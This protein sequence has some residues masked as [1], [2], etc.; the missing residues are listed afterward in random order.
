MVAPHFVS[1]CLQQHR[2]V[3]R[4]LSHQLT[5]SAPGEYTKRLVLIGSPLVICTLLDSSKVI[6]TA[7]YSGPADLGSFHLHLLPQPPVVHLLRS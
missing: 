4:S 1:S 2:T 3:A 6:S 5:G 7:Q